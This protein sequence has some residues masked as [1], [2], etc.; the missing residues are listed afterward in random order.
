MK[1]I[2]II[3]AVS[4]L[5]SLRVYG[6]ETE[7]EW[8]SKGKTYSTSI[9]DE[10][11]YDEKVLNLYAT[12]ILDPIVMTEEGSVLNIIVP[13]GSDQVLILSPLIIANT[14]NIIGKNAMADSQ[15]YTKNFGVYL[16]G[17][18]TVAGTLE[19][20]KSHVV[21]ARMNC[22]KSKRRSNLQKPKTRVSA[23]KNNEE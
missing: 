17:E 9:E 7:L 11:L 12:T 20:D 16:T 4:M 2:S 13:E 21:G 19:A 6:S 10:F 23:I 3:F 8:Q 18:F 22:E 15:I 1:K 14:L 5:I